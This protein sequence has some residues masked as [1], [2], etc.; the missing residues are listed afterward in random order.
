MAKQIDEQE[1]KDQENP[2]NE[3]KEI[4][5]LELFY[6]LWSQK[7][8][9]LVWCIWGA[10]AGLIIAFSIPREYTATVKLAPE[11]KTGGRSMSGGLS[12]LASLAGVSTTG[13]S[14][15][16]AMYPQ[17]YPDIVG[18]VPFLTSLFDVP[19]TDKEGKKYTVQEYLEEETSGPWWGLIMSLPGKVFGIFSSNKDDQPGDQKVNNFQL[20]PEENK[21]VEALRTR[22]TASVD[23]KTSVI[24]INSQMQDPVVS[25][26]LVDTVVSRLRD[27]ITDYRTDK[28]RQD[29]DYALKLN[30]EAQQEYYKAQQRLADYIDRNQNLAT[31]SARI[32]RERLE[33][34]ASLAFNL[35]N[36]TSLQVQNAK[37]KVQETTPVYTE[38]TPATVPLKPTSPRKGLILGG[39]IFLAFV[40]CAA[41]ILFGKPIVGEYKVKAK[42][43]KEEEQGKEEKEET[44]K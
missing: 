41:W 29:L 30:D 18:S 35:Y 33:N 26:I 42:A 31:Q 39:F 36:E 22:V 10:I 40:A 14:G 20:T 17:L 1:L 25:A 28:S 13:N 37:S 23:Q 44:K 34:E 21:L 11:V 5:L 38:I 16:D 3:E 27:Y 19:V 2:Q 12:A 43:L 6:K 15:T 4:D 32:T 7:R 24:T 9:L 8:L